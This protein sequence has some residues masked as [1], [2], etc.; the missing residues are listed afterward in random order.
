[1]KIKFET[2]MVLIIAVV[3]TLF[4]WFVITVTNTEREREA[5]YPGCVYIGTTKHLSEVGFYNCKGKIEMKLQ[6]GF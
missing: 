2:A 4:V 1:M 5:A 3:L 6:S